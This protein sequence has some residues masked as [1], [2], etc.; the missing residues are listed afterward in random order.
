MLRGPLARR[1]L[2]DIEVHDAAPE[3]RLPRPHNRSTAT[4]D[5]LTGEFFNGLS[6]ERTFRTATPSLW[7]P[8][9][10][11]AFDKSLGDR[12]ILELERFPISRNREFWAETQ[13]LLCGGT[14]HSFTAQIAID[15]GQP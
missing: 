12:L 2:G 1:A 6:H 11:Q 8:R 14:C 15:R 13:D 5:T 7:Q 4:K 9:P 3:R 10:A